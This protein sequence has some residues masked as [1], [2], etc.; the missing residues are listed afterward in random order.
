MADQPSPAQKAYGD[1]AP[2]L[3]DYSDKVLFGD[4]WDAR[5]CPSVTAA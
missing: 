2:A 5:A 3:A 4:V 1:V